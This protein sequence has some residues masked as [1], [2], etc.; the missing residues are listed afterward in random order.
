MNKFLKICGVLVLLSILFLAGLLIYVQVNQKE[1]AQKV[2][3]KLDQNINGE[4]SIGKVQLNIFNDF[5]GLSL[6]LLNLS[7]KDSVYKKEIFVAKRIYLRI[8]LLQL[9]RKEI[10][11]SK[12]TL[13]G[14]KFFLLRDSSGYLNADLLKFKSDGKTSLDFDLKELDIRDLQFSFHEEQRGQHIC[15]TIVKLN[16]VMA[17]SGL[18]PGMHLSGLMHIDSM[19]FKTDK[20]S[21]FKD[22]LAGLELNMS[23]DRDKKQLIIHPSRFEIDKQFYD[24]KGYFDFT[25]NP[26][27]LNLEFSNPKTDFKVAKGILSDVILSYMKG[28]ELDD[29][30]DVKVIVHGAI[31]PDLPPEIDAHFNL[32]NA[33]MRYAGIHLTRFNLKGLFMNHVKPGVK[34]DDPN[35][36]LKFDVSSVKVEGIPLSASMVITDLKALHLAVTASTQTPL[37][38]INNVLPQSGGKFSEGDVDFALTYHGTLSAYQKITA[39]KGEDTLTGYFKI[40]NGVYVYP[41]RG[42]QLK[43]INSD[44]VF[45]QLKMDIKDLS[46][47]LNGNQLSVKGYVDGVSRL[48]SNNNQKMTGNLILSAPVFNLSKVLTEKNI[49]QMATLPKDTTTNSGKVASAAISKLI[50]DITLNLGFSSDRFTFRKFVAQKVHGEVTVSTRGLSLKDFNLNVCKGGITINGALQ[51]EAGFDKL[52]GEVHIRNVNMQQFLS[53]ADNFGQAAITS[54]NLNGN[55]SADVH[56]S[57]PLDTAYIPIT[58]SMKGNIYFSLKGGRITSFAP[59]ADIGKTIFKKRDFTNVTFDEIK[60]TVTLNGMNLTIRRMEI[61]S[62]IF[63]MFIQG[64][65]KIN[66]KA[67]LSIQVPLSNLKKQ[68]LNYVPANIGV[69]AKSGANI[70]LRVRGGG[71]EKL[72]ITLDSGAK[73]RLKREALL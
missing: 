40:K 1:L 66:G 43:N 42:L 38:A 12:V 50:D 67:D 23:F 64:Q 52:A 54:E 24:G 39:R 11:F 58:D 15:F 3:S 72:K 21:F 17:D 7:V 46:A 37:A 13:E 27:L 45:D 9:L 57:A 28:I 10:D 63:R 8:N 53:D 32:N 49:S 51:T 71:N 18:L 4:L 33:S 59:L 19:M 26:G 55:L 2:K 69:D 16:G 56:F 41:V 60:D 35:S 68:E 62:S 14:G 31:L 47:S 48:I 6:T 30:V 34:N 22:K 36:A 5:P 73:N 25:S 70:F 61:A 29:S 65:Y 20:G 44:V